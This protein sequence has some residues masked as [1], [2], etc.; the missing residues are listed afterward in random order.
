MSTISSLQPHFFDQLPIPSQVEVHATCERHY[1]Y[2]W[3][4]VIEPWEKF[5]QYRAA[6]RNFCD[7]TEDETAQ[8]L[9]IQ[10]THR[11]RRLFDGREGVRLITPHRKLVIILEERLAITIKKLR[12]RT[13]P[14]T[15]REEIVRSNN[16][17][18]RN[19]R[20]W[21]QERGEASLDFPR[22]I[23][24]YILEREITQIS[25]LL[26]YPRTLGL[27]VNWAFP[28]PPQPA[29]VSTGFAPRLVPA[30]DDQPAPGFSI[31]PATP[32]ERHDEERDT[33]SE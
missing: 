23:L 5:L 2:L 8:W 32:A 21:N 27:R 18:R 3:N 10:A 15:G 30:A 7:F 20:V 29:L 14:V 26:A 17:T 13:N 31:A 1:P 22:I 6:D 28:I 9:T 33:G 24:G 16:L 25:I 11:A 12:R 19:R 4:T